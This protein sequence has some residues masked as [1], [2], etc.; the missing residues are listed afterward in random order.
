M[1]IQVKLSEHATVDQRKKKLSELPSQ[2]FTPEVTD[3]K[4][5]LMGQLREKRDL[6]QHLTRV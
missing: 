2:K 6:K 4:I 3:Q 5:G 1:N